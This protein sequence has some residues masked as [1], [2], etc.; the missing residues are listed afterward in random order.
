VVKCAKLLSESPNLKS[1][2]V[3]ALPRLHCGVHG[4]AKNF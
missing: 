4:V 1:V 2:A 3:E